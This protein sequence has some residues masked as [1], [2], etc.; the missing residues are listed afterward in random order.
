MTQSKS[1]SAYSL[2]TKEKLSSSLMVELNNPAKVKSVWVTAS[3]TTPN[4]FINF[5]IHN[6]DILGKLP[7]L[8]TDFKREI[9]P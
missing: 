9:I 8:E 4:I 5:Q 1:D 6:N 7:N 3:V 2:C